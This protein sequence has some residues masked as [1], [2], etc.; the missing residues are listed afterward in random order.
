MT[1]V[2]ITLLVSMLTVPLAAQWLKEPTRNI[3][4]TKDG[5]AD[6][7]AP[8][9][10]AADGKPDLS[11]LWR[12][13]ANAYGGNVAADLK[14]DEI[15]PAAQALYKQRMEDLGKDDP[16]TYQC[17]PDGPRR[18]IGF[19]MAKFVQAPNMVAILYED[20]IYRQIFM[21]GRP[22]PKDPNP[23]WMGY[24]I[25]HWDGDTLVVETTGYNDRSWL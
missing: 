19:G 12:M 3:P 7:K 9:P 5:K 2:R 21:D 22:L 16:A 18:S 13:E 25:G 17:T 6:L 11:G 14:P 1:R 23:S 10:K 4:R 24:S 15:K 20:L 8:A